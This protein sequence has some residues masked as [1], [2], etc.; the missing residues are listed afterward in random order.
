[1]WP[2]TRQV[3]PDIATTS[4]RRVPCL[5]LVRWPFAEEAVAAEDSCA[6]SDTDLNLRSGAEKAV[7]VNHVFVAGGVFDEMCP[8]SLVAKRVRRRNARYSVIKMEPPPATR[9]E[10]AEEPAA[11][12]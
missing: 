1:M 3:S 12:T 7:A 10:H 11:T 8:G 5:R 9:Y 2:G 4:F 6:K